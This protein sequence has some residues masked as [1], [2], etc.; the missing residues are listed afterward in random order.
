MKG[1]IMTKAQSHPEKTMPRL[2]PRPRARRAAAQA[3]GRLE[4]WTRTLPVIDDDAVEFD[5]DV[6]RLTEDCARLNDN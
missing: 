4:F 5:E 2:H 1:K 3:V 6:A